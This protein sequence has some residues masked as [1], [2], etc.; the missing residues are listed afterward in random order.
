MNV[1]SVIRFSYTIFTVIFAYFGN[2]LMKEKFE[3]LI[4]QI[5]KLEKNEKN[6][7][8]SLSLLGGFVLAYLIASFFAYE[9]TVIGGKITFDF[10]LFNFFAFKP[11]HL[12]TLI[13]VAVTLKIN[14]LFNE[15]NK[16]LKEHFEN[17]QSQQILIFNLIKIFNETF[18]FYVAIYTVYN[19]LNQ[20]L[21]LFTIYLVIT[22]HD[23]I[24]Y[25]FALI[26]FM[27]DLVTVSVMILAIVSCCLVNNETKKCEKILQEK[28]L[29]EKNPK[30]RKKIKI[31]TLQFQHTS[32]KFSCGLFEFDLRLL[33]MVNTLT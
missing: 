22:N 17:F 13:C 3:N 33:T 21:T 24:L 29:S 25:E 19:L 26:I 31:F 5:L 4:R 20:L 16:K 15:F 10:L 7:K 9:K 2:F 8:F 23:E 14:F 32:A 6:F 28:L 12:Q 11:I 18:S 27:W 1:I 30:T